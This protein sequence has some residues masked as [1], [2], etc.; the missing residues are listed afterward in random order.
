MGA[1]FRRIIVFLS[2]IIIISLTTVVFNYTQSFYKAFVQGKRYFKEAKYAQSL[3]YFISALR[4]RPDNMEAAK[5]L[6]LNY[7]KLGMA[8]KALDVLKAIWAKNPD[9][10]SI[11]EELA[12]FYYDLGEYAQAEEL[13]R[14]IIKIEP[15][16]EA[17]RKL[18]EVLAWQK[19]YGEAIVIFTELTE[20]KP[21]N[22]K[23]VELLA[24]IYSWTKKYDESIEL[25][26]E[27]LSKNYHSEDV[28]FKLAETLRFSG[29]DE[30]AVKYYYKY[31]GIN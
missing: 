29:R 10:V 28:T 14:N 4:A 7:Q 11:M 16:F 25:Y 18:A 13:Y 21:Q 27:L 6:F 31:L 5:Y 2:A 20:E 15:S 26:K 12:D 9:D 1:R 17:K 8:E 3:P 22:L 24:D 30:E 23:L 19:K